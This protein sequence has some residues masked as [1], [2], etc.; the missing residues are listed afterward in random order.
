MSTIFT[1]IPNALWY[2]KILITTIN[3]A[4]SSIFIKTIFF[5]LLFIRVIP[6]ISIHIFIF[7]YNITK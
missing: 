6:A 4:H 7:F 5:N 3:I 1:K 2:A